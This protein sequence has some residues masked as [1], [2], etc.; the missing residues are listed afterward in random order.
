M[1]WGGSTPVAGVAIDV[2]G[3]EKL[4]QALLVAGSRGFQ[5]LVLAVLAVQHWL[6]YGIGQFKCSLALSVSDARVS[7]VLQKGYANVYF[8]L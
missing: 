5:Q 4:Q 8:T 7:T 3:G 2:Q 1:Q 6:C